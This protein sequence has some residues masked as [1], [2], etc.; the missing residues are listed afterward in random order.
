MK[1]SELFTTLLLLVTFSLAAKPDSPGKKPAMPDS[2][3]I[4]IDTMISRM[5]LNSGT[6]GG[7][8]GIIKDGQLIFEKA[9]GLADFNNKVPNNISML[10]NL[11]SVSKQFTAAS[12]LLLSKENKLS[13]ADDVRKYLPDF[14]DYGFPITIENLIHHTSGIK[15]C[16]ALM[17]LAGTLFDRQNLEDTYKLIIK[18]KSLNFNPGDEYSY[19]NSGYVL[20]AR[21]IEK[22]SGMQFSTFVEEKLLKPIGMGNTRIYD[23][24]DI[25]IENSAK[26]HTWDGEKKFRTAGAM[27]NTTVGISNAYTCLEDFL[28][29]DNNFYNNLLADWDFGKEMTAQTTFNNGKLCAYAFGLELSE[30]RGMKTV[31]HQG[32]TGDFTA[33]FFQIP[34]ERFSVIC[35]FNIPTDVTGLTYNITNLFYT[36]RIDQENVSQ[37]PVIIKAD[38]SV[39]LSYSGKYF[40]DKH[41]F[42]GNVS[43]AGDHLIFE[44]PCQGSFEIYPNSDSTYIMTTADVRFNFSKGTDGRPTK[45]RIIQGDQIF[46][47]SYLGKDVLPHNSEELSQ[48]VGN[49]T[50]SEIN[51]CYP[52]LYR[53]NKLYVK[54]PEVAAR[55]CN[56]PADCELVSDH[57]DFFASR[58]GGLRFT[59]NDRNEI[60]GFVFIDIGRAKNMIFSKI[61]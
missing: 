54:I 17:L 41:G 13:L 12:V 58:L 21:I 19:S 37:K 42:G 45:V 20:L 15:S 24:E 50:S 10:F 43:R 25:V 27:N 1:S 44:A 61:N 59:R 35:L 29:W 49:F 55:F 3:E 5:G 48:F 4:R 16:D 2:L 23:S 18:Q 26:G 8:V 34:S 28:K 60:N 46:N 51:V 14:P 9:Y 11:G 22:V 56:M 7:V 39:L 47:L 57:S 36:G 32:G 31:A 40:D 33:Q 30:Y 38:T 52:V 6:P 53:D